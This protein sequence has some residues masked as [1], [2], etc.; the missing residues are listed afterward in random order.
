MGEITW[1]YALLLACTVTSFVLTIV[2][3]EDQR[4]VQLTVIL[5]LLSALLVAT[6]VAL[7]KPHALPAIPWDYG[8][9]IIVAA[10]MGLVT[11]LLVHTT[12]C[13]AV[14]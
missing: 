2:V 12:A 10:G 13:N 11:L 5:A 4:R 8:T 9:R 6:V 1:R 7:G 3:G 14:I